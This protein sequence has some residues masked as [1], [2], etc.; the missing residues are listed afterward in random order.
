MAKVRRRRRRCALSRRMTYLLFVS[1]GRLKIKLFNLLSKMDDCHV[2]TNL[3]VNNNIL[4]T[5]SEKNCFNMAAWTWSDTTIVFDLAFRQGI[6]VFLYYKCM[7][8][9][10]YKTTLVRPITEYSYFHQDKC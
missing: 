8:V 10:I 9:F 6:R 2:L 7:Y 3:S 1:S 5:D 4:R